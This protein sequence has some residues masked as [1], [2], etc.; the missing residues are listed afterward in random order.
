[1]Y[2]QM[3]EFYI[4]LCG[5]CT[6][7]MFIGADPINYL[8]FKTCPYG[9][10]RIAENYKG[11][12]DVVYRAYPETAR[13][14]ETEFE[15]ESLPDDVKKALADDRY[16]EK[17]Q[18][19]HAVWPQTDVDI[20][21][22]PAMF[23]FQYAYFASAGGMTAGGEHV[24]EKGGF[25]EFPYAVARWSKDS[26]EKYGRGPGIDNMPDIKTLQKQEKS[27]L[28]AGQK[29]VDP[30]LDIPPGYRTAIRTGPAGLNFRAQGTEGIRPLYEFGANIPI[31][32]DLA[33][34][35][36]ERIKKAFYNDVFMLLQNIQKGQMTIPELMERIQEKLIILGPVIGRLHHEATG[37]IIERSYGILARQF[38]PVLPELPEILVNQDIEI[39]YISPL[40]KAQ[41]A[42]EI[43]TSMDALNMIFAVSEKIPNIV[44][45]INGDEVAKDVWDLSGINQ[46][47][48][49]D[50]RTVEAIRQ[51]RAEQQQ[52]E[53]QKADM[54][55][56]AEVASKAGGALSAGATLQ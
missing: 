3:H 53:Q 45:N 17:F 54:L 44:D 16:E 6:G 22:V 20:G 10:Y 37:P 1:F 29:A 43:R 21:G 24:I 52:V 48:L 50:P 9:Q 38:P 19:V 13:N 42:A 7:N 56:A 15:G 14:L 31:G 18:I 34:Q 36:R 4:D 26:G 33:E 8:F 46:K 30:P 55:L 51:Q 39:E 25:F 27:I 41:R 2:T 47:L 5:F 28:K 12:V 32:A 11:L 49:N 23:P 40:A 35:R